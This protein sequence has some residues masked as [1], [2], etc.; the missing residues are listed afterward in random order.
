MN[1]PYR[2]CW[3]REGSVKRT[4]PLGFTLIELLAV[5]AIIAILA[6]LLLPVLVRAKSKA[7]GTYCLN[8]LKQMQLGW[9]MYSQ[10]FSDYLAPNSD[11]GNEGKDYDNPAWVAGNM[12][13]ALD[14]AS[15]SDD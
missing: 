4:G 11:F 8:N 15:L 7:Q 1:D 13:Y 5:I 10:D 9:S 3:P 12:S 14:P 2:F 6:S